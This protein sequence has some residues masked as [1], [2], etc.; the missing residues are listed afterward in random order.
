MSSSND[1]QTLAAGG[2]SR[3]LAVPAAFSLWYALSRF[4]KRGIYLE[5]TAMSIHISQHRT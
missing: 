3:H 5:I 1:E 4:L 2:S